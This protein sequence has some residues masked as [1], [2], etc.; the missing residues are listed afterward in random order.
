MR[1]LSRLPAQQKTGGQS[2]EENTLNF[3]RVLQSDMSLTVEQLDNILK[4][5]YKQD[6]KIAH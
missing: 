4:E 1:E 3:H 6:T 5:R 2:I